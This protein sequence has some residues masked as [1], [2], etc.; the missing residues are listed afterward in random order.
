M[1]RSAPNSPNISFVGSS[2]TWITLEWDYPSDNGAPILF[3][4]IQQKK[5]DGVMTLWED[6][7][8]KGMAHTLVVDGLNEATY[9]K[10]RIKALNAEGYSEWS[11]ELECHTDYSDATSKILRRF[12]SVMTLL[13]F[14]IGPC[15]S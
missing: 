6:I 4:W 8:K 1:M 7:Y 15:W 14:P 9:Y 13:Q 3:Y 12:F 5:S 10:Y 2:R 11:E